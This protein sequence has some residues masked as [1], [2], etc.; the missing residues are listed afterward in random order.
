MKL[1]V[2]DLDGTLIHKKM[3]T[4]QTKTTIALLQKS[5]FMFT[6]ATGRHKDATR[7][8]VEALNI[9]IPVICTNGAVIYDFD[10]EQSI[11]KDIIDEA[12]VKAVL[13]VL[14]SYKTD[15]L[16][17]TTENI[18]STKKAKDKLH[19]RIGTFDSVVVDPNERLSFLSTGVLKILL[20]EENDKIL[21]D[22]RHKLKDIKGIYLLQSQ[23]SFLDIGNIEAN[24]GRAL[25]KLALHLGISLEEVLA[26]GDQENDLS[27]IKK[28]KIGVA[29]GNAEDILK[30]EASFIT[31][32]FDE[33]GF[34]YAIERFIL[35]PKK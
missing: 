5:G 2:A 12:I 20:I 8:L 6:L 33:E 25:E 31:K 17:Y 28:A 27:M 18:V 29:M 23:K 35:K 7:K 3:M 13:T 24:K 34:T 16:I 26:I 10:R 14:D 9:H 15:Y 32:P 4:D 30:K 22:I 19:E 21:D 11:H 1:I